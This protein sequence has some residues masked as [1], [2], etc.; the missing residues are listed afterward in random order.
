MSNYALDDA[1]AAALARIQ[2]ARVEHIG[3]LYRDRESFAA[4]PTI[5][6]EGKR[7][8][9]G[10]SVPAG[11]L[12]ALFHNH[13]GATLRGW[14]SARDNTAHEFS[15]QDKRQAKAL[16]VPSYI[17]TAD[18]RVRRYDPSTSKAEDVLAQFPIDEWRASIARR[19]QLG[20]DAR[21]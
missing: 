8:N 10:L 5:G 12:A 14:S 19:F 9:G 20:P 11:A 6:G 21:R 17:T 15:D 4:T 13:P 18:G 16:G 2:R 3:A 1:A 7:V